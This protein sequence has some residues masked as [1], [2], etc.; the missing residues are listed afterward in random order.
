MR[1]ARLE[2]DPAD[3]LHCCLLM[4]FLNMASFKTREE[5]L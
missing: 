2:S 5:Q 1:N 4:S 3:H